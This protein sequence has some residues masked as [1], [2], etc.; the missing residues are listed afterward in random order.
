M[1]LVSTQTRLCPFGRAQLKQIYLGGL[2][3]GCNRT[4]A[5]TFDA[6]AAAVT[7]V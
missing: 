2:S 7:D 5:L 1:T 6:R 4:D 3:P